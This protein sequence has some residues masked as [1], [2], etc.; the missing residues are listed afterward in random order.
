MDREKNER[1]SSTP[2]EAGRMSAQS[3]LESHIRHLDKRIWGLKKLHEEL[4][5]RE[6]SKEAEEELWEILIQ[7][8]S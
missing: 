4:S 1:L 7:I 5:G 3:V 2:S 8:R 6:L